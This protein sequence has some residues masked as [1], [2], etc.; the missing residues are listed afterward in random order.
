[1]LKLSNYRIIQR[2]IFDS[3]NS[4]INNILTYPNEEFYPDAHT[5]PWHQHH[6]RIY[7]SKCLVVLVRLRPVPDRRVINPYLLLFYQTAK[8][9]PR[10]I[11][12]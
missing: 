7:Q 6:L 1:M 12:H 3:I 4:K 11:Y 9:V 5:G 10:L 8:S 2:H